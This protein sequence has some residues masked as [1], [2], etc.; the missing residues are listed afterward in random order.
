ME[1]SLMLQQIKEQFQCEEADIQM[2][3]PLTLAYIGDCIFDVVIRSVVVLR[4]NR[5]VNGLHKSTSH[6]VKAKTQ[7]E[8]IEALCPELTQ[9]ELAVYRRGRNAKSHSSAKNA[10]LGDYH[11]ATGYEAL[12]GYL[13]LTGQL[14]RAIMLMKLGLDR[15]GMT[16]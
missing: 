7:A 1:K 16:I 11:K 10:S 5:A 8:M 6:I 15:V 4:G 14:D 12:V 2:Y 9:E 13:Y 3:S